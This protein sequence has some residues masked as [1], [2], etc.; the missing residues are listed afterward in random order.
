MLA[1]KLM[2]KKEAIRTLPASTWKRWLGVNYWRTLNLFRNNPFYGNKAKGGKYHWRI[3]IQQILPE[4]L[5][6][7]EKHC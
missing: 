7:K 6:R 2:M 5:L 3:L 1:M 4:L